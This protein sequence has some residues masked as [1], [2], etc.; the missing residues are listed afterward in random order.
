MKGL[1]A[2]AADR[3]AQYEAL[4]EK[5]A[6]ERAEKEE[7]TALA[8]ERLQRIEAL[9]AESA[10]WQKIEEEMKEM[11]ARLEEVEDLKRMYE[12]R[13]KGLRI[14]LRAA[15][16]PDDD[17]TELIDMQSDS[18]RPSQPNSPH[19][20]SPSQENSHSEETTAEAPV[21]TPEEKSSG[22]DDTRWL[23]TL[24]QDM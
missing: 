10:E 23:R 8:N 15:G 21:S 16:T 1:Q 3:Q 14:R 19:A 24:P 6:A 5:M 20:T 7:L 12:R 22:E 9:E 11:Y 17:Y 4:E 13:I 18:P 2:E